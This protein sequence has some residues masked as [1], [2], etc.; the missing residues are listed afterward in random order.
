[1]AV[2]VYAAAACWIMLLSIVGLLLWLVMKPIVYLAD[3]VTDDT[4]FF[5]ESIERAMRGS[6]LEHLDRKLE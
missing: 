4:L 3:T 1:M 2:Q 5:L 6:T